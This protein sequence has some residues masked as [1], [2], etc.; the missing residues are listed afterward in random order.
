MQSLLH[1][2]MIHG[3]T[4]HHGP[5]NLILKNLTSDQ[6]QAGIA[7]LAHDVVDAVIHWKLSRGILEATETWPLVTQQ[8]NTFWS[9]TVKAHV[10][11]SVVCMCRVFDKE[12]KSLHL[13]GLL[14]IIE[15]NLRL[16][17]EFEF[18]ARLRDNPFVASLADS[19]RIPDIK[20]LTKDITLCSQSDP[21]VKRL[22]I[23]RNTAVA[24]LSQELKLNGTAVTSQVEITNPEFETLLSRANEIVNRYSSLFSAEYFSTQIVGHDDYKTIFRWIQERVESE[25]SKYRTEQ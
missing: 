2:F 14:Q 25:R 15:Q 4:S 11:F 21:I 22:T 1:T 19:A 6:L 8:S 24:H 3:E 17:N 16:F 23:H 12:H 10:N 13:P 9:L 18:R 20:Q 5:L 7:T